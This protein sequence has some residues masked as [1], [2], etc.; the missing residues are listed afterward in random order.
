MEASIANF[1]EPGEKILIA[2]KGYLGNRL[3]DMASRYKANV[4]SIEKKWG[5]AFTLE[6]IKYEIET[7]KP[8]IFAIV[9][10]ETSTGVLQPLEGIGDLCRKN[11]CLFLVDAVTSLGAL[12]LLLMIGKLILLI[13]VAKKV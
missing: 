7:N 13:V 10:A 4:I 1:I 2:K 5:E 12:E 9:H 8:A 3:V 11:N 6:E